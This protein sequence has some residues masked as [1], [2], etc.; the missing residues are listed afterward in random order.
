MFPA[1]TIPTEAP[2][3]SSKPKFL[4]PPIPA[5]TRPPTPEEWLYAVS[6]CNVQDR[7][8]FTAPIDPAE[9]L[10]KT[11][12]STQ[13]LDAAPVTKRSFALI[14][15][16]VA[17]TFYDLAGEVIKV[18][19]TS[20]DRIELY[21]TDYTSNIFLY[22]YEWGRGGDDDDGRD[23]DT[24]GYAPK[25]RKQEWPGPYG[26]MTI[27]IA[28][29]PPHSGFALN[30]VKVKDF[31]W[32]RNVRIKYKEGRLE[33]TMYNGSK[34]TER[35]DVGIL[36]EKDSRVNEAMDRKEKYW[37]KAKAEGMKFLEDVRGEKRKDEAQPKGRAKKR[38]KHL[39]REEDQ[40]VLELAQ[41]KKRETKKPEKH[42]INSHSMYILMY[43]VARTC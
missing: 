43:P 4:C 21:I 17:D 16:V 1:S 3:K 5:R 15:D 12:P 13:Y 31:V 25:R 18:H 8:T 22:N 19:A 9:G 33:G 23:G 32:L 6:I 38:K 39:P 24:Y 40:R 7:T 30:E 27:Q 41:I 20:S 35:V 2:D 36:G 26:K 37:K 14:K 11:L 28:L 29:W 34:F 42:E 10:A